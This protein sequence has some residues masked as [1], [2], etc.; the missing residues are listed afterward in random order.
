MQTMRIQFYFNLVYLISR[1]KYITIKFKFL[2]IGVFFPSIS[3]LGFIIILGFYLWVL[4]VFNL[5]IF[6]TKYITINFKFLGIGCI[7]SIKFYF[8]F[9]YNFRILFVGSI[10][11]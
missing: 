1:T 3:I 2:G 9:Y 10:S 4:L 5:L 8:G 11:I 7:F 6:R